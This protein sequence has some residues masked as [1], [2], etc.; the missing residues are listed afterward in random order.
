MITTT[1]I[2]IKK[3]MESILEL[4]ITK[5]LVGQIIINQFG[6]FTGK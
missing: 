5:T 2:I 3:I 4:K 1:K 6:N